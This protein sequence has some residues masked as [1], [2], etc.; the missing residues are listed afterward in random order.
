MGATAEKA[1]AV[2]TGFRHPV[3]VLAGLISE[4]QMGCGGCRSG[5]GVWGVKDRGGRVL[6][7]TV[8]QWGE[9]KSVERLGCEV[10]VIDGRYGKKRGRGF[11]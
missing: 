4:K 8:R 11:F 3:A 1:A 10:E 6:D 5:A 9:R 2:L 7:G